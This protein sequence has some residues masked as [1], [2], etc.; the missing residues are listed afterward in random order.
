MNIAT[1]FGEFKNIKIEPYSDHETYSL[2]KIENKDGYMILGFDAPMEDDNVW[3]FWVECGDADGHAKTH[4][5]ELKHEDISYIRQ[6]YLEY[7]LVS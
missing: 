6:M 7:K 1:K 3:R 4:N 5:A 2:S